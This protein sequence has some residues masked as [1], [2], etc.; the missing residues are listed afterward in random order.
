MLRVINH[1][2]LNGHSRRYHTLFELAARKLGTKPGP[3]L[4]SGQGPDN[5]F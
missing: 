5:V 2:I 1:G 4:A 3:Q